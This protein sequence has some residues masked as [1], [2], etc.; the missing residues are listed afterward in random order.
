M[1]T[2][3]L[4]QL[5]RKWAGFVIPHQAGN[6]KTVSSQIRKVFSVFEVRPW[7]RKFRGKVLQRTAVVPLRE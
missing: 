6:E 5:A 1:N 2:S 7:R 3:G 4:G